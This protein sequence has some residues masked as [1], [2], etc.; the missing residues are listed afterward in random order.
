MY[1]VPGLPS[2]LLARILAPNKLQFH[3]WLHGVFTF[4]SSVLT[5][6]VSTLNSCMLEIHSNIGTN[7]E[8]AAMATYASSLSC[9]L[10]EYL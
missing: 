4:D 9:S 10:L 1:Q 3:H 6:M 7:R 2:F 8:A 5:P